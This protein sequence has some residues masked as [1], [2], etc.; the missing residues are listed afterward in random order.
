MILASSH[1][2]TVPVKEQLKRVM[3][4]HNRRGYESY[5]ALFPQ[6][7]REIINKERAVVKKHGWT[8]RHA[9]GRNSYRNSQRLGLGL[10][11]PGEYR[12]VVYPFR[13]GRYTYYAV[14]CLRHSFEN[15]YR[16]LEIVSIRP[17]RQCNGTGDGVDITVRRR[18]ILGSVFGYPELPEIPQ[19]YNARYRCNHC[20]SH[21]GNIR[22]YVIQKN[23]RWTL[24]TVSSNIQNW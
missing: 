5:P 12:H 3:L 1:I 20:L 19:F 4:N 22:A 15:N 8:E 10:R 24:G 18:S 6:D 23:N 11:N 9:A 16:P 2:Y 13:K 21:N 14:F 17:C 7:A